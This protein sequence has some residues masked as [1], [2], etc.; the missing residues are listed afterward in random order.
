M[1]IDDKNEQIYLK[2]LELQSEYL[3]QKQ[4]H[5]L[6]QLHDAY[7][8]KYLIF[9][10]GYYQGRIENQLNDNDHLWRVCSWSLNMIDMQMAAKG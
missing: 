7:P 5:R 3:V 1:G 2:F 8:Q 9:S 6:M 10:I 4:Y